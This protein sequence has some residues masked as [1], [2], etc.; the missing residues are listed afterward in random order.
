G[1]GEKQ[2]Q[3]ADKEGFNLANSALE[4]ENYVVKALNLVRE[5][6]IPEDASVV[7]MA[8]PTSEPF[9]NELEIL[10]AYLKNGGSVLILLDPPPSAG[11]VDF[12]KRWNIQVGNNV[13]V[14]PTGVGR[15]FGAGPA[16]PLVT[17]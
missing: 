10:D 7:V 14:D 4:K 5:G 12:T 9:P 17:T 8:G 1:H 6:K 15:L 2:T 11:F 13:V 3:S 16:M